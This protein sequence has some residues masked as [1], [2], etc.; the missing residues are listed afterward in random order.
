MLFE[1]AFAAALMY[2]PF[3]QDVFSTAALGWNAIAFVLPFPFIVWGA[4][5]LRRL[6][7][8]RRDASRGRRPRRRVVMAPWRRSRTRDGARSSR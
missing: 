7:I 6:F 2:V 3:L 8:R 4:D 1:I 5:E